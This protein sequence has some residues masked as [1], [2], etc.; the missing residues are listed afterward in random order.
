MFKAVHAKFSLIFSH[1]FQLHDMV[2]VSYSVI[3]AIL[4]Q[5][6]SYIYICSVNHELELCVWS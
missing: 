4:G 3:V 6:V 2:S 5:F 1:I